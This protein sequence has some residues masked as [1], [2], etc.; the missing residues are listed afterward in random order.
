MVPFALQLSPAGSLLMLILEDLPNV[1]FEGR[2]NSLKGG[3]V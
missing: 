1:G 2:S 3:K